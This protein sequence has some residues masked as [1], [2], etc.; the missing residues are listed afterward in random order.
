MKIETTT[1]EKRVKGNWITV[2]AI[3]VGGNCVT[4]SG[5]WLRIASVRSEEWLEDEIADPDLYIRTLK[6]DAGSVLKADIFTFTQKPPASTPRYAYPH[7]WESVAA[8]HLR[9]YEEWWNQLPQET[10]KNVRRAYRRGV[11]VRIAEFNDQLLQG[12][13]DVNNDAPIRQGTPNAYFGKSIEEL[14]RLFGEFEGRC[15]FI[16]AYHCDQLIGFLHLIYRGDVASILNLSTAPSHSDKRPANALLEK[17]LNICQQRNISYITYGLY[18]YG[19]KRDNPLRTFKLRNGFEELLMPRYFVPL[20]LRGRACMALGFHRGLIGI[21]PHWAIALAVS[22]RGSWYY[23]RY[24]KWSFL[25]R[26]SLTAEQS[27]SN[28]QMERSSPPAGSNT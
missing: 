28:R 15:S 19:N 11:H 7:E 25:G 27:I 21:L 14:K 13:R 3:K 6:E 4:A 26:R 8:I 10:R 12:I 1:V 23:A 20:T 22:I 17:A 9:S 16:G 2:P 18:N 5:K 24:N